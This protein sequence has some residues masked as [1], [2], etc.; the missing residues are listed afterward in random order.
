M[1]KAEIVTQIAGKTGVEKA[2]VQTTIEA[3][4]ASI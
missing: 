1:T 3:F 4:M 2:A